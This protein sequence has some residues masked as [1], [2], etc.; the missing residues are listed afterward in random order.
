MHKTARCI[1]LST[2]SRKPACWAGNSY[3]AVH[4]NHVPAGM[5]SAR[6]SHLFVFMRTRFR[7]YQQKPTYDARP[8]DSYIN[9]FRWLQAAHCCH[10]ARGLFAAV[11]GLE[12]CSL[13]V[14]VSADTVQGGVVTHYMHTVPLECISVTAALFALTSQ[15]RLGWRMSKSIGY[16][17]LEVAWV[18]GTQI[19]PISMYVTDCSHSCQCRCS[20]AQNLH[21]AS[22]IDKVG[23]QGEI[24]CLLFDQALHSRPPVSRTVLQESCS[25]TT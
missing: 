25:R 15:L 3:T 21:Q 19:A 17:P 16:N 7:I 4:A 10:S 20:M 23:Y 9:G 13:G 8:Y 12:Q 5:F 14:M 18:S 11:P 1:W 6:S 22:H 2:V 24:Y